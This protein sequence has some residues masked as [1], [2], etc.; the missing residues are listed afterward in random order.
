MFVRRSRVTF[1]LIISLGGRCLLCGQV[2]LIGQ[3]L[4][5]FQ[6]SLVPST[7]TATTTSTTSIGPATG[8]SATRPSGAAAAT[9]LLLRQQLLQHHYSG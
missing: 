6:R 4:R 2:G 8:A 3:V 1:D 9:A 7:A 5:W